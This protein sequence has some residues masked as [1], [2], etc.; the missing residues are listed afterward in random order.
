M[1]DIQPISASMYRILAFM[2]CGVELHFMIFRTALPQSH[3]SFRGVNWQL[4]I[5]P[6][7]ESRVLLGRPCGMC[8]STQ[9]SFGRLLFLG[10]SLKQPS[11]DVCELGFSPLAASLRRAVGTSPSPAPRVAQELDVSQGRIWWKE[12]ILNLNPVPMQILYQRPP[13]FRATL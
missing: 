6:H 2:V 13:E 1:K 9:Q 8:S 10:R 3:A 5:H 4:P 11:S 7:L 12:L